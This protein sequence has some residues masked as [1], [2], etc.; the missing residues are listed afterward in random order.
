ML[1]L[2]Q[3]GMDSLQTRTTVSMMLQHMQCS[4]LKACRSYLFEIL[5]L[6][7]ILDWPYTLEVLE[8]YRSRVSSCAQATFCWLM[9]PFCPVLLL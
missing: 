9:L 3:H 4:L 8:V 6:P 7:C 5:L 1:Q 2:H